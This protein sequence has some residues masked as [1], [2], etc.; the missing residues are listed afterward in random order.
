MT[1]SSAWIFANMYTNTFGPT[2]VNN[3]LI[4]VLIAQIYHRLLHCCLLRVI[5]RKITIIIHIIRAFHSPSGNNDVAALIPTMYH[6][7]ID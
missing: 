5:E 6:P 3:E 7:H 4:L 2:S 1:T